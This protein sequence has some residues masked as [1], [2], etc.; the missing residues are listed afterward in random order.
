MNYFFNPEHAS[1]LFASTIFTA[2]ATNPRKRT[3]EARKLNGFF[4][5]W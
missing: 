3:P 5:L 4:A 1:T 2:W